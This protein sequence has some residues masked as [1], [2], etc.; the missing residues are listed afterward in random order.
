LETGRTIAQL[1]SFMQQQEQQSDTQASCSST[2][3]A[4]QDH[5]PPIGSILQAQLKS[6][7][8]V[9]Q[10]QRAQTTELNNLKQICSQL[11]VDNEGLRQQQTT[12]WLLIQGLI[13]SQRAFGGPPSSSSG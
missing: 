12:T 6:L 7:I 4:A 11:C 2:T 9:I 5:A 10:H 8:E 13:Q 3:Q 1:L